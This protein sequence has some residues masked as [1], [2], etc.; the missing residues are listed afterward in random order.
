[1]MRRQP[2]HCGVDGKEVA[3]IR[4]RCFFPSMEIFYFLLCFAL[5]CFAAATSFFCLDIG[6]SPSFMHVSYAR[7][8]DIFFAAFAIT[9]TSSIHSTF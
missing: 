9:Q 8:H 1:M 7:A 5:L 3:R 6:D 2:Y 4:G